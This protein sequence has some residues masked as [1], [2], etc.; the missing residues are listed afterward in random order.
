MLSRET[1]QRKLFKAAAFPPIQFVDVRDSQRGE[2]RFQP[3]G[4]HKQRVVRGGQ[5]LDSVNVKVIVMSVG[6]QY[7]I[8][9]RQVLKQEARRHQ[10]FGSSEVSE[11]RS[12][13]ALRMGQ[14]V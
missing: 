7:D 11:T 8:N 2:P 13:L 5:P 1:G 4:D 14:L 6:D 3:Q 9:G 12:L 10:E